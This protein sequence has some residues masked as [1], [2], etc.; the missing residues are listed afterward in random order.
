M[1]NRIDTNQT[2]SDDAQSDKIID[3]DKTIDDQTESDDADQTES[4]HPTDQRNLCYRCGMSKDSLD[5]P[6]DILYCLQTQI[7]KL[8]H[9]NLRMKIQI[10]KL[11]H[12]NLKIR[13]DRME[14]SVSTLEQDLYHFEGEKEYDDRVKDAEEYWEQK[15]IDSRNGI[16]I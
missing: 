11:N 15:M 3:T 10:T 1:A 5:L 7:T 16:H 12:D 4:D 14:D 9:E 2:E 13:L 8:D 6:H